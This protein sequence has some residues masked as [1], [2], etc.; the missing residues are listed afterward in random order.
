MGGVDH[1]EARQRP[2]GQRAHGDE[3]LAPQRRQVDAEAKAAAPM[4]GRRHAFDAKP[5]A[6]LLGR[7]LA[8]ASRAILDATDSLFAHGYP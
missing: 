3:H 8:S 6:A 1:V 4:L 2:A 5:A 7:P